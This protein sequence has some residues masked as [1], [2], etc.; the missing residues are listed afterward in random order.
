METW[1]AITS[2][3]NVRQFSQQPISPD[4]LDRILEAARRTPS[5]GNKQQWDFIVVTDAR[6]ARR[7]SEALAGERGTCHAV[8]QRSSGGAGSR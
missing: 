6:C 4:D 2:R 5:A 7:A 8:K 3:R 1:D